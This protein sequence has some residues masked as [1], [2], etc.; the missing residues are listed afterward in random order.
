MH[1]IVSRINGLPEIMQDATKKLST[2]YIPPMLA[3]AVLALLDKKQVNN[4]N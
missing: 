2:V 1:K 4:K 3:S